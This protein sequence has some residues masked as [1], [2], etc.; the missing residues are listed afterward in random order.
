MEWVCEGNNGAL[1]AAKTFHF[2]GTPLIFSTLRPDAQTATSGCG[3]SITRRST[4]GSSAWCCWAAPLLVLT[5]L[6]SRVI[7]VAAVRRRPGVAGRLL[8]DVVAARLRLA[9]VCGRGHRAA[10]LGR[11][12]AVP[13]LPAADG[14]LVRP[15]GTNVVRVGCKPKGRGR[16]GRHRRPCD[17][18]AAE[19]R[20]PRKTEVR[21]MVKLAFSHCQESDRPS[22]CARVVSASRSVLVADVCIAVVALLLV[23][24]RLPCTRGATP[25]RRTDRRKP[26][27]STFPISDLKVLLESEPHR[28]LLTRQ[29]YDE[30][31]KKAK[32]TPETHV[33]HPAVTVSSDYDITV[34]DG[35][36]KLHG[37]I[38][39][40][41]LE[42]GLHAVPWILAAWACWRPSSTTSPPRSATRPT[43]G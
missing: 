1:G 17:A 16:K 37:T 36:A 30:L 28:V 27:R 2:D 5:S 35:R 19:T 22:Q 39:I 24:D 11:R 33:P 7:A 20:R 10:V 31:V 9:V 18:K 4:P 43:G 12:G 15:V 3:R 6:A 13:A 40:D 41:V 29:E 21:A 8:A 34:D 23:S 25:A 26:A 32:K 14:P 42:D 38:A